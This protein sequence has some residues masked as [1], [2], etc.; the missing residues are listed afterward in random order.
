MEALGMGVLAPGWVALG[1]GLLAGLFALYTIRSRPQHRKLPSLRLWRMVLRRKRPNSLLSKYRNSLFFLLQLLVLLAGSIALMRPYR[2]GAGSGDVLLVIDTSASMG[3]RDGRFAAARDKLEAL[4]RGLGPGARGRLVRAGAQVEVVRDWTPDAGSL[5]GAL[6]KVTPSEGPGMEP[7]ELL[8]SLAGLRSEN[9]HQVHFVTDTLR[10]EDFP[11]GI[12][13]TRISLH[14]VGSGWANVAV[15][16]L[17]IRPSGDR[18]QVAALVRNYGPRPAEVLVELAP[19]GGEN[20][21]E[22]IPPDGA[23]QLVVFEN[24]AATGG[25]LG[26]TTRVTQG[27]LDLLGADDAAY[28]APR[29]GAVRMLVVAEDPAPL[30]RA[31]ELSP[32]VSVDAVKPGAVPPAERLEDYDLVLA[33]GFFSPSLADRPLLLFHPLKAS[34]YSSGRQVE[35]PEV[36][37][38]DTTHPVNRYLSLREVR[39]LKAARLDLVEDAEVLVDADTGPLSLALSGAGPRQVVC[40][41]PLSQTDLARRVSFP[42]LLTNSVRWLLENDSKLRGQYRVGQTLRFRGKGEVVVQPSKGEKRS[43]PGSPDGIVVAAPFESTGVHT[44][45]IGKGLPLPYPVNLTDPA[46]SNLRPAGKGEAHVGVAAKGEGEGKRNL[47]RL[48]AL[49]ALFFLMVEW[50]LLS[51]RGGAS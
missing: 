28:A 35:S 2:I 19:K 3:A 43:L 21:R 48:L 1:G 33:D 10:P 18:Y 36:T 42:I 7:R 6:G 20:R 25:V 12:P 32:A 39:F 11:A 38:L 31:L 45:R 23:E 34:P 8:R 5:V 17:D 24:A 29:R 46:E 47:W 40:A 51:L 26:V 4:A 27:E 14:Y 9:T 37:G 16:R 13:G 44:V 41:F 30:R 49:V 50:G 15:T 22:T